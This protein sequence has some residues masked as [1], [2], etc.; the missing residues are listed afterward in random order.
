MDWLESIL[1]KDIINYFKYQEFS[2]IFIIKDHISDNSI[3]INIKFTFTV[4]EFITLYEYILLFNYIY[5]YIYIN[6]AFICLLQHCHSTY[7][8]LS[9]WFHIH[10][11]FSSWFYLIFVT[12][13]NSLP[14]CEHDPSYQ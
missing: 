11:I 6:I 9:R 1:Q 2:S 14:N 4:Y 13:K 5:I 12:S 3:Q 7:T 10:I 8:R